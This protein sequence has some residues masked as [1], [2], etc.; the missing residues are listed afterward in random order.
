MD[1][2]DESYEKDLQNFLKKN[3]RNTDV[4]SQNLGMTQKVYILDLF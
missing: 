3:K 2:E 4:L 1:S